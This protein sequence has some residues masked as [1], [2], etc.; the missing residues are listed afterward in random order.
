MFAKELLQKCLHGR[1]Q[2]L[3]ESFNNCVWERIPK[4]IFVGIETLKIGVMDAMLRF[5]EGA[6]ARTF[7]LRQISIKPGQN[8]CV[9]LRK[10]DRVRICRVE[11]LVQNLNKEARIIIRKLKRK[12][13]ITE[14]LKVNYGQGKF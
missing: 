9:A 6:Y 10:L 5:N 1:T 3:N 14:M 8:M 13:E 11:L 12:R 2:N 7:V 4:N